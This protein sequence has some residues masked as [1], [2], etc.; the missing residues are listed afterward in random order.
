MRPLPQRLSGEA[1]QV[2]RL[3]EHRVD[4]RTQLRTDLART[5]EEDDARVEL[6]GGDLVEQLEAVVGADVDVEQDHV[7]RRALQLSPGIG[8]GT[9]N[10]AAV[11]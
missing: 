1:L 8:D 5:R 6:Q 11:A 10:C 9:G 4:P 7:G 2:E 3:P